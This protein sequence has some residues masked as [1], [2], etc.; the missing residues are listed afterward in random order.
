MKKKVLVILADGFE[1]IEAVAPIDILRRAELDVVVA[2]LNGK[3]V[4]GSHGLRVEADTTL[5]AYLDSPDAVV[6]PGGLPGAK[7]L[8]ESESVK[9]L[10][11]KMNQEKKLVGAICAS[12]AFAL[13]H[14]GILNGRKATCYPGFERQFS[15]TTTF[16]ENRVVV[17]GNIT[18]SRG[19]GSAIEFALSLVEQLAGKDKARLLKQ[20]L[21]AQ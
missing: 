5:A 15:N 14:S 12:P 4:T 18:T 8:D 1:E 11:T 3:I 13:T 16:L 20:A 17:D 21:L 2:G 9:S 6:L 7:N 19:P 10:L